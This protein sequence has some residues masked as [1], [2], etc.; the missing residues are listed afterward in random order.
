[1]DQNKNKFEIKIDPLDFH[2]GQKEKMAEFE[3]LIKMERPG[4][5]V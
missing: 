1:M 5:N 3:S 4:K 2:I